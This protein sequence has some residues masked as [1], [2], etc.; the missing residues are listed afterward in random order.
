M[1][2]KGRLEKASLY[3]HFEG[4][5]TDS[6]F[7]KTRPPGERSDR[8]KAFI[9]LFWLENMISDMSSGF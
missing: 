4:L 2:K 7:G 3:V 5:T 9:T 8:K 1:A 6:Y